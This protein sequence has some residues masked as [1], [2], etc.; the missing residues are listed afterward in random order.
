MV[1]CTFSKPYICYISN[2]NSYSRTELYFGIT[3]SQQVPVCLPNG[4]CLFQ[5]HIKRL[6]ITLKHY[7]TLKHSYHQHSCVIWQNWG[8]SLPGLTPASPAFSWGLQLGSCQ[9]RSVPWLPCLCHM[10]PA[11]SSYIH[12]DWCTPVLL[13][14]PRLTL[15][16]H[17][18]NP[19]SKLYWN[20]LKVPSPAAR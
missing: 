7:R 18:F 8:K 9:H 16:P 12:G 4:H 14:S 15:P 13:S 6:W 11:L 5:K 3:K 1:F 17:L 10:L 20:K 2:V 19:S